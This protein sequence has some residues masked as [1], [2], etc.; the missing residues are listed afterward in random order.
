MEVV[1]V[2]LLAVMLPVVVIAVIIFNA[3]TTL[4]LKLRPV[5]CKLPPITL[6]V[7]LTSPPVLMFPPV[8][9]P[10]ALTNVLAV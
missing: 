6:P 10:V 5:A 9:L 7:A 1:A 4:P 2:I 8:T 3:L